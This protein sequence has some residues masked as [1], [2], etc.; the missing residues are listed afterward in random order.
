MIA[1]SDGLKVSGAERVCFRVGSSKSYAVSSDSVGARLLNGNKSTRLV[2]P[3]VI[4]ASSGNGYGKTCKSCDLE[5]THV[6]WL[7]EWLDSALKQK[8]TR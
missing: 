7:K 1:R 2:D 5:K 3:E 8:S 6:G 4:I